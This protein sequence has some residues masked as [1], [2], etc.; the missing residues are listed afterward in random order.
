MQLCARGTD[1]K[2]KVAA[3]IAISRQS[4]LP[5]SKSK[6]VQMIY[7]GRY[8]VMFLQN[9][10]GWISREFSMSVRG[11]L[12]GVFIIVLFSFVCCD[13]LLTLSKRWAKRIFSSSGGFSNGVNDVM[14]PIVVLFQSYEN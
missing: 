1:R 13:L 14:V 3:V 5:D 11:G 8:L 4:E 12:V 10:I 7:L 2:R 9:W 6:V